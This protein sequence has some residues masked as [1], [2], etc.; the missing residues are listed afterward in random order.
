[1]GRQSEG[2][3]ARVIVRWALY[4]V[5]L[6]A[7]SIAFL[8]RAGAAAMRA[9]ERFDESVFDVPRWPQ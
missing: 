5:A 3:G 8:V 6:S 4:G 9:A 2:R 1:M 7:A